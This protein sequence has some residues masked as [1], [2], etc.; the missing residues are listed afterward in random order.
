MA[1]AVF[2]SLV[3]EAGLSDC[4]DAASAGTGGWHVGE[5]PHAGTLA[6]LRANQIDMGPKR[7]QQLSRSD[8]SEYDYIVAMD[9]ENVSDI[10][11]FFGRR[12]PRLLEFAPPGELRGQEL[13]VPDPYYTDG[14]EE[15]YRLVQAGCKG[16]LA[17]IREQEGV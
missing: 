4:M 13:D 3:K 1:E 2:R 17:Q 14:F 11:T 7:A 16:L 9:A 10:Q 8:M 5:R 15:V 12:V 6:V